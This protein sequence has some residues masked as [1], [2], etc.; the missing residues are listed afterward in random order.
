LAVV[1]WLVEQKGANVNAE[2]NDEA[3]RPL[4]YAVRY[5]QLDVV[6]WFI[7]REEDINKRAKYLSSAFYCAVGDRR[8]MQWLMDQGLDDELKAAG[9]RLTV[10]CENL[11]IARWLVE[12]EG[13]D[14][15][16]PFAD[17]GETIFH[18]ASASAPM[19]VVRWLVEAKEVDI[20]AKD[21]RG[22][23]GIHYAAGR[24]N[25]L[26]VVNVNWLVERGLEVNIKDRD[27]RTA[28]HVAARSGVFEAVRWCVEEKGFDVHEGDNNGATALHCAAENG[29]SAIVKWLTG[30]KGVDVKTRDKTGATALHY[31]AKTTY[32][33]GGRAELSQ[34]LF[35]QGVDVHT[36][37][38][39]GQTALDVANSEDVRS[40]LVRL[41]DSSN[42]V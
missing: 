13:V 9:L 28:S 39:L 31:V 38:D 34:W 3:W 7:E 22:R 15:H 10:G 19:E 25:R 40:I 4:E 2:D 41:S 5:G 32:H 23:T 18:T 29:S 35:M 42:F 12:E 11:K 24:Y 27:G 21:K 6:K 16:R 33:Q 17:S 1:R 8:V 37:D 20:H 36:T 26:G 14:V 30:E